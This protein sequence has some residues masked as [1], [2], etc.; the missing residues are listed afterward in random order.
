MTKLPATLPATVP[1]VGHGVL[2]NHD[3]ERMIRAHSHR[4]ASAVSNK[5]PCHLPSQNGTPNRPGCPDTGVQHDGYAEVLIAVA[6]G[7]MSI[8]DVVAPEMPHHSSVRASRDSSPLSAV[9]DIGGLEHLGVQY[10]RHMGLRSAA[11]GRGQ[12]CEKSSTRTIASIFC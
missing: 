2:P 7:L 10:T 9:L 4:T 5:P 6:N 11:M 12:T 3:L 1:M 8:P